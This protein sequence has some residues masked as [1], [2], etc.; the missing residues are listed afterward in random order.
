LHDDAIQTRLSQQVRD[1]RARVAEILAGQAAPEDR[2]RDAAATAL[3]CLNG[4]WLQYA[5]EPQ[6]W[7]LELVADTLAGIKQRL[8]AATADQTAPRPKPRERHA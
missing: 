7:L 1:V 3:A 8:D 6:P 2:H 5:L 4:F